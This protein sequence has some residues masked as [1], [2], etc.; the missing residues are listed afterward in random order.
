MTVSLLIIENEVNLHLEGE[1]ASE[2]GGERE[3]RREKKKKEGT[4]NGVTIYD[5]YLK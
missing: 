2:G 4:C 1:G 3:G 5:A